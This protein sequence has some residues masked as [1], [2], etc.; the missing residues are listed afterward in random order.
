MTQT[1]SLPYLLTK[2]YKYF[3]DRIYIL[4]WQKKWTW[5]TLSISSSALE[6]SSYT[7]ILTNYKEGQYRCTKISFI[8][9]TGRYRIVYT[10]DQFKKSAE[11]STNYQEQKVPNGMLI[12][13]S[14]LQIFSK[15][16]KL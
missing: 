11:K 10:D 14:C 5:L 2:A 9:K 3:Q 16:I 12:N 8:M 4:D 1:Q 6:Y 13:V 15:W 7:L